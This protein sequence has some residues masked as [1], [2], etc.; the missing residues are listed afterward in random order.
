MTTTIDMNT[1]REYKT[2]T[3]LGTD[4]FDKGIFINDKIYR[5]KK[6]EGDFLYCVRY[7]TTN[8]GC[9]VYKKLVKK[10]EIDN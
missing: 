9:R 1:G 3:V 4:F 6:D 5:I 10:S 2:Q 7:V 8:R